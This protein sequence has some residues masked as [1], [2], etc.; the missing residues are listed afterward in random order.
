[1]G[2]L[3]A[4][5]T[6][7]QLRYRSDLPLRRLGDD[8]EAEARLG[9]TLTEIVSAQML[10][11]DMRLRPGGR[12]SPWSLRLE[13]ALGYYQSF[14]DTW[15]R[16]ALLRARPVAGAIEAGG[17]CSGSSATSFIAVTSTSTRCASC[18]R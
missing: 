2:K 14:G 12:N 4:Q 17:G 3:G 1:M 10:P 16:A 9:E 6:Q 5:R 8:A 7:S 11:V 13:G 15:E 18:A